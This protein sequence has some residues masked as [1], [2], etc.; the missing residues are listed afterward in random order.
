MKGMWQ[1]M[2]GPSPPAAVSLGNQ[3]PV[4]IGWDTGHCAC[5][6]SNPGRQIG[7]AQYV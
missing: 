5:R 7:I 1:W 4:P 6:I 2:S 3:S